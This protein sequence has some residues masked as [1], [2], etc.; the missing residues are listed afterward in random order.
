[1]Q[2]EGAFQPMFVRSSTTTVVPSLAVKT[3]SFTCPVLIRIGQ[4]VRSGEGIR[5]EAK[6]TE[7]VGRVPVITSAL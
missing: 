4:Y 1:M 6:A 3:I 5:I 2:E 7:R